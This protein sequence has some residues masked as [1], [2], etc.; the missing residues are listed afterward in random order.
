MSGYFSRTGR[1]FTR[2]F[3]ACFLA[4]STAWVAIAVAA[5]LWAAMEGR[6]EDVGNTLTAQFWI[7][8]LLV[9]GGL[10]STIAALILCWF[11]G[12][13][14]GTRAGRERPATEPNCVRQLLTMNN[15][16]PPLTGVTAWIVGFI[17]LGFLIGYG[18]TLLWFVSQ[19]IGRPANPNLVIWLLLGFVA[20][21][22]FGVWLSC[23]VIKWLHRF[24]SRRS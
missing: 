5:P 19:V 24:A 22:W 14:R 13:E 20:A 6:S 16:P 9:T 4:W 3:V 11:W 23:F 7:D 12:A 17:W 8:G 2:I 10:T 21:L 15:S 1:A 18:T